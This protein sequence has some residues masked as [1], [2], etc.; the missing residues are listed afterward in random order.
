MTLNSVWQWTS[1]ILAGGPV[2]KRLAVGS[3]WSFGGM[4]SLRVANVGTA[5]VIARLL[6]KAGLGQFAMIN[7]TV[8]MLAV[9]GELGLGSTA[10]RHVALYRADDPARA[11]RIV[12][13]C[14][15]SATLIGGAIAALLYAAAPVIAANFLKAPELVAEFRLASLLVF[16]NGL[17]AIH[18]GVLFGLEAFRGA[19]QLNVARASLTLP[20]LA[21]GAYLAGIRGVVQAMLVVGVVTWLLGLRL[22]RSQCRTESIKVS[23]KNLLAERAVLWRFAVPAFFASALVGPSTWLGNGL[24]AA[25]PGGYAELGLFTAANQWRNAALLAPTV[26]GQ[27]MLPILSS[28]FAGRGPDHRTGRILRSGTIACLAI[29]LPIGAALVLARRFIMGMYGTEFSPHTGILALVAAAFVLQA[30]QTPLAQV[31]AAS[32]SMWLGAVL[33]L[34]WSVAFLAS[35]GVLLGHH[36]GAAGLALAYVVSYLLHSTWTAWA[37]SRLVRAAR[38]SVLLPVIDGTRRPATQ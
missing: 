2:R 24:L 32:G 9:L 38:Q 34:A 13:L 15:L 12:A 10:T 33:N 22:V 26:V 23:W 3:L 19:A 25:Q 30:A 37:G 6:G 1:Q 7:S 31:I 29:A 18:L 36:S 17:V 35:A 4:A 11:G 8:V 27:T 5:I 16:L 14:Y 20:V 21:S 28:S